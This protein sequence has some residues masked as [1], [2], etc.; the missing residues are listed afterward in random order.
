MKE[1]QVVPVDEAIARL[2]RFDTVVDA[3]SPAE[4]ALDRLPGAINAPVLDDEQRA[5][6]G[7]VYV[8]Q[9]AFLARRMGAAIVSRNIGALLEHDFADRPPDWRPLV[10][11]WRGGNR[12][13]ALATVLG[14]VGWRTSI[15]EGGYRAFRRRVRADLERLPRALRWRVLAGR[16][17]T[18]KSEL[19]R[20]LAALGEQV[21]DLEEIARHRGSVLGVLP[22]S[23]QPSQKAFE[24]GI[25]DALRRFDPERAVF[26]E[27]E[28]RRVGRCH[29]P[30]TL[31]ESM[32]NADCIR[33]D[34]STGVRA[35]LLLQEYRHFTADI[36]LLFERLDRLV[37]LHG[38][39]RIEGWKHLA[40][41]GRWHEFVES[42]LSLHYDP[43]YDRSIGR[44]YLRIDEAKSVRIESAE[45][46]AFER[47]ARDVAEIALSDPATARACPDT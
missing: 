36:A 45:V 22:D 31:I 10:Y 15:L 29:I 3:R 17:G 4:F 7:T 40:S 25:W 38:R 34:A 37:V 26:I 18:G 43:T 20:Q 47:A 21:L 42:L 9:S 6:V 33:I 12:S 23:P 14:R 11:C 19:L 2:D 8:Q 24:T 1:P 30:D 28:S 16:T 44:N 35:A 5:L 41:T 46:A 32:R 13:S 39:E 27:S